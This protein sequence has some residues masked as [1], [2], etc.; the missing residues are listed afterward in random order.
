[1]NTVRVAPQGHRRGG[2]WGAAVTQQMGK[3]GHFAAW[4]ESELFSAEIRAAFRSL[5]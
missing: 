3:G 1:M 4:E 2:D 5:R